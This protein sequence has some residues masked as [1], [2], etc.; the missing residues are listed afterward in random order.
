[1]VSKKVSGKAVVRN[2]IKRRCREIIRT[3]I[4]RLPAGTYVLYAKKGAVTAAY[5]ECEADI[6]KLLS[7]LRG[8]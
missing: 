4:A 8:A 7:G 3:H 1:M 6:L 2:A 5:K